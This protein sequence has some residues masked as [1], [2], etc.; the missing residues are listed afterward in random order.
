MTATNGRAGEHDAPEIDKRLA[1]Q[2]KSTAER[3]EHT[4]GNGY[5]LAWSVLAGR[6]AASF[7]RERIIPCLY[8]AIRDA[9]RA[10][11]I[12]VDAIRVDQTE[13][14][15][16]GDTLNQYANAS[17]RTQSPRGSLNDPDT[18]YRHIF[19]AQKHHRLRARIA[20]HGVRL[21]ALSDEGRRITI[22]RA[23]ALNTDAPGLPG[24]YPEPAKIR[25]TKAL[26]VVVVDLVV[27]VRR[28]QQ[29]RSRR[30]R[31]GSRTRT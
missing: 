31:S 6:F 7:D 15:E 19:T 20:C 10:T 9:H 12:D 22:Q 17:R 27:D 14:I 11:A 28:S 13:V 5:V 21:M 8:V 25:F 24:K 3:F 23:T 30:E 4:A 16:N 2:A 1:A 26:Q 18:A 29:H